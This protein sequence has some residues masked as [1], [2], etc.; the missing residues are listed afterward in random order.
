MA[1][2]PRMTK[3][4]LLFRILLWVT[5]LHR[6]WPGSYR[7]RCHGSRPRSV[8][9]ASSWRCAAYRN[10]CNSMSCHNSAAAAESRP[11][12]PPALPIPVRSGSTWKPD[13]I[14]LFIRFFWDFRQSLCVKVDFL[15]IRLLH[16]SAR[17]GVADIVHGSVT[18]VRRP[19]A[20]G[21]GCAQRLVSGV[22]W[23][24]GPRPRP[25]QRLWSRSRTLPQLRLARRP[26]RYGRLPA[27]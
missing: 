3:F 11:T 15:F 23:P 13:S 24:Y 21:E 20:G 19:S 14:T 4:P 18:F 10:C 5:E 7:S 27:R 25:T 16:F 26:H 12:P 17:P 1:Y 6:I 22:A 9:S 2:L 8:A